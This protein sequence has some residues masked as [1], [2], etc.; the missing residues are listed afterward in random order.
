MPRGPSHNRRSLFAVP[1]LLLCALALSPAAHASGGTVLGYGNNQFG[2]VGN[3][4]FSETG[5]HCLPTPTL[6]GGLTGV[7]Q[8][9]AAENHTLALLADGSV[10]AWGYDVFGQLG[11]GGLNNQPSPVP[12]AGLGNATAVAPGWSHSVALLG[13]GTVVAWGLNQKG[14]LGRGTT[15]GPE[16][17]K[18]APCSKVPLPVPGLSNVVAISADQDY[19][20][21]LLADGTVMGWGIDYNGQLGDGVGV[22]EGCECVDHP[23][24]VPGVSGVTAISA[25]A[26]SAEAL[27]EDGTVMDWG[28]NSFGEL[29]NGTESNTPPCYC[30]GPVAVPGLTS[31]KAIGAGAFQHA[32]ALLDGTVRVWGSNIYGQLGSSSAAGPEDCDGNPCAKIPAAVAGLGGVQTIGSGLYAASALLGDGSARAWGVNEFGAFGNGADSGSEAAVPQPNLVSGASALTQAETGGFAL[33]GPSQTLTV[34]LTGDGTGSAFSREVN[35]PAHC[36]G[37]YPQGQVDTLQAVPNAGG[38]AGFSGDCSGTA[39]C[40]LRMDFDRTV[41]ATFGKPTG[42]RITRAKVQGKKNR[43]TF[44]FAAPGAITGFECLLVKPRPKTKRHGKRK[45]PRFAKCAAPKSYKHLKPGRYTF[46]VRALDILGAD[47]HPAKKQFRVRPA[48]RNRKR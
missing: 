21:A 29:G 25:G 33:I 1:A 35:C 27:L 15:S 42:T 13:N 16:D 47:A 4:T 22:P 41:T 45:K 34:A 26:Y 19:N 8:V 36:A 9:A 14:Q 46:K 38:F 31:V 20:L 2:Q 5:C 48:P 30:G 44:S 7:T 28:L 12:V 17:C 18:G 3:G 6:V 11:D 39:N 43:A 10:R 24:R 40:Q 23:V 32:A 37:R